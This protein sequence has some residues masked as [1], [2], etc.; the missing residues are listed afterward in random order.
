MLPH[1]LWCYYNLNNLIPLI[2]KDA[3]SLFDIF[4][5]IAVGDQRGGVHLVCFDKG[6]GLHRRRNYWIFLITMKY[7]M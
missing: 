7:M 6:E 5:L 2:F 4:Q 3:V 1:F